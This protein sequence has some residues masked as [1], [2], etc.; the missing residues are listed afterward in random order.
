MQSNYFMEMYSMQSHSGSAVNAHSVVAIP[1]VSAVVEINTNNTSSGT[2]SN[3][4]TTANNTMSSQSGVNI[5][6]V[7]SDE[8]QNHQHDNSFMEEDDD[9]TVQQ[10]AHVCGICGNT[11]RKTSG[12][13][14]H[15]RIHV[16][17]QGL[18]MKMNNGNSG[19]PYKCN[20]CKVEFPNSS[21]FGQHMQ[22]E[23]VQP[24]ALKCTQCGCFRPILLTSCSPFRCETCTDD[25]GET[26]QSHGI[27]KYQITTNVSNP[28]T[29]QQIHITPS[30]QIKIQMPNLLQG[31]RECGRSRRPRKQ[32]QCPDC[33]KSYKHQSTLAMHKKIHSG[34]YKYKC[35]YCDKEFYLTEYYNRHMRVHTKERPYRCDVCDKSFSQSNTLTQHKR[36][37]TGN[38]LVESEIF[39]LTYLSLVDQAICKIFTQAIEFI[40][41][42]L[43]QLF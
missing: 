27:I 3:T 33:D 6:S 19:H 18:A 26:F 15:M 13:K 38:I 31:N 30:K 25:A 17:E 2:N 21:S 28:V 5:I 8:D 9:G 23:H 12:L 24:Q 4:V 11:F 1:N 40:L 29:A 7:I 39:D 43:F 35:E 20:A 36:I 22:C 32:H 42:L 10:H 14:R 16:I 37:H 41:I 34:E